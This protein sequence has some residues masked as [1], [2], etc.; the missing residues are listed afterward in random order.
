ML[1]QSSENSVMWN[2]EL[3]FTFLQF[4]EDFRYKKKSA[5]TLRMNDIQK[6]ISVSFVYII[7]L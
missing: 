7:F 5:Q 4:H 6:I 2:L 1:F 3:H